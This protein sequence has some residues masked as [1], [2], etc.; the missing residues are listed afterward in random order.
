MFDFYAVYQIEINVYEI[1]L[2]FLQSSIEKPE[3]YW[4]LV[5]INPFL[6]KIWVTLSIMY[7]IIEHFSGA[8]HLDKDL[9]Y[10]PVGHLLRDRKKTRFLALLWI[11]MNNQ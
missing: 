2:V 7:D 9:R 3:L 11:Q 8:A 10:V 4:K 6:Q 1:S 5:F